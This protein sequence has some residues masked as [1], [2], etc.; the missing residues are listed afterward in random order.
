MPTPAS[1]RAGKAIRVL[2]EMRERRIERLRASLEAMVEM[3]VFAEAKAVAR[4]ALLVDDNEA[5][6]MVDRAVAAA[7][8]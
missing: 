6:T 5:Q 3:E 8:D 7:T 1:D 4:L 2:S